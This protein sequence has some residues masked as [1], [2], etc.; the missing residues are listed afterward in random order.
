MANPFVYVQLQTQDLPRA[1]KF[2]ASLFDWKLQEG[3]DPEN[4]YTE[5]VVGEGT[6]GGM[7]GSPAPGTP[8]HWLPYA[9]VDDIHAMTSKAAKLGA[10]ILVGPTEA[11]GK[12]WFSVI[13]D[14]TGAAL[15]LWKAGAGN[16]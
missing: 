13:L 5:I 4:D 15:A 8:S 2:Y 6:A 12:G 10:A 3:P 7:M 9:A 11:P 14:P 16:P 1:K